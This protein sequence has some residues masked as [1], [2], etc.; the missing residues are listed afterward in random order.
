LLVG[1]I[2]CDLH[3]A[4]DCVNHDILLSKIDFYDIS[5]KANSF[6]KSYLQDRYQRVLVDQNSKSYYSEWESVTDWVPQ[7]SI[8]VPLLFLSYINDIPSLISN[9][10]NPI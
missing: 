1:S 6:I 4:F 9:I 10:S 3:K 7:G 2:F 8:L 5:G